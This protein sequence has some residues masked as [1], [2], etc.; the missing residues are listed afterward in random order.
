MFHYRTGG[1]FTMT[2]KQTHSWIWGCNGTYYENRSFGLL[3]NKQME[4]PS[5]LLKIA[6]RLGMVL[7]EVV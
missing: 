3:Q 2:A 4:Y 6:P 7:I 5:I 1:A